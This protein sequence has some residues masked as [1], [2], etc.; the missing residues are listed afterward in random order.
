MEANAAALPVLQAVL[1]GAQEHIE[2][3]E[4]IKPYKNPE[5]HWPG[6]I[7]NLEQVCFIKFGIFEYIFI[8]YFSNIRNIRR[9][10]TMLSTRML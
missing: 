2:V 1:L 9:N 5:E 10:K 4:G 7:Q 3:T 6:S 8:F